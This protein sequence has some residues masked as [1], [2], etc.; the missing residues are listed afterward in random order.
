MNKVDSYKILPG[1][2]GEVL[3]YWLTQVVSKTITDS[4][5]LATKDVPDM[6]AGE[7]ADG[8]KTAFESAEMFV[9]AKSAQ[10]N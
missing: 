1:P 3:V 8:I 2:N 5:F 4:Y 7:F 10:Q 6:G 9:I